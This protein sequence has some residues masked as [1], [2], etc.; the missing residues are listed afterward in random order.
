[1]HFNPSS[2]VTPAAQTLWFGRDALGRRSLLAHWPD[3]ADG[4]LLLASASHA[5]ARPGYWQVGA[6]WSTS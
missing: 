3:G 1:V 4:R 2:L 5:D 6:T